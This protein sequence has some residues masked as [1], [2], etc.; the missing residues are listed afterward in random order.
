MRT[1]VSF[2]PQLQRIVALM[3]QR[4]PSLGARP[5]VGMRRRLPGLRGDGSGGFGE[6]VA[7]Q[8]ARKVG[9][10][11][12]DGLAAI[13][14]G[15]LDG[16]DD[17]AQCLRRVGFREIDPR[18]A[19]HARDLGQ[20]DDREGGFGR[21]QL[22]NRVIGKLPEQATVPSG[23]PKLAGREQDLLGPRHLR[24]SGRG[25][26][27]HVEQ[28]LAGGALMSLPIPGCVFT[29]QVAPRSI[30]SAVDVIPSAINRF[31]MQSICRINKGV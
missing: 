8:V 15:C 16:F 9:Q 20:A 14:K 10:R 6:P 4:H 11:L 30:A 23:G 25:R 12:V 2:R 29:R 26:G 21:P 24:R 27:H 1:L 28:S 3:P 31:M 5:R 13:R 18:T 22:S 19:E 7:G 17:V